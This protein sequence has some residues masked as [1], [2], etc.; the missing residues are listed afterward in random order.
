MHGMRW[1][2]MISL[3]GQSPAWSSKFEVL[4]EILLESYLAFKL[5]DRGAR[6]STSKPGG[7]MASWLVVSESKGLDW[8]MKQAWGWFGGNEGADAG[9]NDFA[10]LTGTTTTGTSF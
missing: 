2:Y 10:N 4:E 9:L 1:L 3:G 7:S 6:S 5:E 8:S